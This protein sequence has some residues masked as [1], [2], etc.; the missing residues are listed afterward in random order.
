MRRQF[1]TTS[2]CSGAKQPASPYGWGLRH[3][4]RCEPLRA[5][6]PTGGGTLNTAAASVNVVTTQTFID[7]AQP[8]VTRV[9]SQVPGLQISF[10]SNSANAAAPGSITIPNIRG[11]TS[12]ETASLID[13][14]PISVGQY[15]DNVTTFLNTF[16]FGDVEVIKG[17]GADS[18]EVNNAIGGTTN[19]RTKDPTMTPVAELLMGVDNRG[20][21]LSNFGFS[22]TVGRLGFVLDFATDYNPSAL[23]GKQVYYDPS[24]GVINGA[25][26]AGNTSYATIPGTASSVPN[27]FPLLACCWTLQGN[28]DQTAELAKLR[29]KL[30]P[31][32]T[33]TLSYLGGQSF[34]D[35][36]GNTSDLVN[37]VF[38]PGDP[39][40]SGSLTPGPMLIATNIFPGAPNS[41]FNNEPITQAE[42]STTLGNDSVLARYYHA[43][44]SRF[45][46]Q[47]GNLFP[48]F[49]FLFHLYFFSSSFSLF[50]L[51]SFYATPPF[52][53]FFSSFLFPH[54]L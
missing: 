4:L 40:Y 47:G 11:A 45:Q 7:Q 2:C 6:A 44:I 19:F 13:G 17:P 14:H 32:T 33:L 35:Q 38:T 46:F 39:S 9:L 51:S 27:G 15:G 18:P 3:F 30:S 8:Q 53:P 54:F 1:K 10:P 37:G 12:Y 26:L 23:N 36:N 20:G 49:F 28:L 43:S 50:F 5:Y 29:Y 25:V 22:D 48:P 21:T 52:F 31:A 16:M 41:E 34:S 24:G 42:I